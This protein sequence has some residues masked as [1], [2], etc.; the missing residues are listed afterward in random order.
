ML[1]IASATTR[2]QPMPPLVLRNADGRY[3]LLTGRRPKI[4]LNG[5]S[6]ISYPAAPDTNGNYAN[7]HTGHSRNEWRP[8]RCLVRLV[9][10]IRSFVKQLL[11]ALPILPQADDS[12]LF[13]NFKKIRFCSAEISQHWGHNIEQCRQQRFADCAR[14]RKILQQS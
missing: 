12:P 5:C 7:R 10:L 11:S 8:S 3:G 9:G 1:R 4:V 13:I 2:H 6:P 14:L